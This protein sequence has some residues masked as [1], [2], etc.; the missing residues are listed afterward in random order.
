MDIPLCLYYGNIDQDSSYQQHK[1]WLTVSFL[2]RVITTRKRFEKCLMLGN[3]F[4]E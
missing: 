2:I 3:K 1:G 4:T